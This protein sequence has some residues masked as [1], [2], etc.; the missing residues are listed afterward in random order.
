MKSKIRQLFIVFFFPFVILM[1]TFVFGGFLPLGTKDIMTANGQEN[2]LPYYYELWDGVHEGKL[3]FFSV[4]S[5]MGYD[6]SSIF[7]IEFVNEIGYFQSFF[8]YSLL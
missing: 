3:F 5:G 7:S 4:R 2:L 8:T 1:V 6:F